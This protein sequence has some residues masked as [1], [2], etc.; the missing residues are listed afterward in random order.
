MTRVLLGHSYF[1]RFDPK[2][3]RSMQPYAPL[4]TLYAASMLRAHGH[5]VSLFDAMLAD[6]TTEWDAMLDS[7][8]PEVAVLFE[9]NFNYL[10]KM[11]L[12][13]MREAAFA[14]AAAARERG[15][16]VIV[17]GAD[18]SDNAAGY[19]RQGADFALLGE[20]EETLCDLL[21]ALASGA[22]PRTL[23]GVA[24]RDEAGAVRSNGRRPNIRDID[25]LP[26]PARDLIDIERYRSAWRRH[27]R[28]SMN[29][30]TSRGCPFHCNWCAKPIWGQRY[31][32]RSPAFV[33]DEIRS[34]AALGVDHLWFMDDILGLKP[35]WLPEFADRMETAGIKLPFKCLARADLLL[36]PGEID[37]LRRAGCEMVWIGA[38]SGSQQV[39]DAMEKGTT[40]D[41]IREATRRLKEAGIGVAFFLQ[42]GYP[43][44][45]WDDIQSTLA[46]VRECDPD[47]VGM[48]VSYPLPGTPFYARVRGQMA[49]RQ[50]WLD[51]ADMAMLYD[52]PYSTA[53]YRKLHSRLHAE[54]RL[55]KATRGRALPPTFTGLVRQRRP[56]QALS[57]ARDAALLPFLSA[58]LEFARRREQ[59][60][61]TSLPV[62]LTRHEASTPS[63]QPEELASAGV[64]RDRA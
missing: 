10:S 52:G 23:A 1:L 13:K 19:L 54:F 17:A 40:I 57:L 63:D 8:R 49:E 30:V 5:D 59:R 34:L 58:G 36:R 50:N 32:V 42:F 9:D 47:D 11:C 7:T 3:W 55:R 43:G 22:D 15:C 60:N 51:S 31:A 33:V 29:L 62:L 14:M 28:F 25:A 56:K 24:H 6:S 44:E 41:E 46:F 2:L 27:G 16:T 53:F 64:S 26:P 61:D 35:G 21:D 45:T 12:L 38:E 4:G 18:V 48:S 20:G 39:L 37:A